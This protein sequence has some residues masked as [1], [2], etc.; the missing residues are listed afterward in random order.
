MDKLERLMD[1]TM[2]LLD[3]ERPLS[4]EDL[5][6][7]IPGYP[8]KLESFRRAFERDKDELRELGIPLSL[9]P[10]PGT[11]PPLDGYRIH[12]DSYYLPDLDLDADE[13]AALHLAASAVAVEGVPGSDALWALGGSSPVTSSFDADLVEVAIPGDDNLATAFKAITGRN[14]V[15]FTYR[16]ETR[17][18]D[19]LRIDMQRGWWYL[20]GFDHLRDEVRVY[21]LDRIEGAISTDSKRT[22]DVQ[23]SSPESITID[24]PWML[25]SGE[26]RTARLL[27]DAP[28][29]ERATSILGEDAIRERGHDGSATFEVE[30]A[31]WL[32]FRSF[33][34]G[35][36]DAAEIIEPA[37][38]RDAMR[39]WLGE[40]AL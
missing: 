14:P 18:V 19:P 39:D 24:V 22:F 11:D 32:A 37:E 33:V 40:V 21:R 26:T 34:I 15:E 9:E 16:G 6:E 28:A 17:E 5:R 27:V 38:W 12:K 4:A 36:L 31:N 23:T 35:F 3:T 8:D 20:T 1:L 13:L 25:G 2:T 7:R 30:V 10:I 29:V